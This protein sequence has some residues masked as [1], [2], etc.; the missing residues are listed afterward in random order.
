MGG[1]AASQV[2]IDTVS[3]L[4]DRSPSDI[5]EGGLALRWGW[6]VTGAGC[7][8]M[9]AAGGAADDETDVTARHSSSADRSASTRRSAALASCSYK[10]PLHQLITFS[11]EP[12][13]AV[14]MFKWI[15]YVSEQDTSLS[16]Q[17]EV[18]D[19]RF[20]PNAPTLL[21]CSFQ[22]RCRSLRRTSSCWRRRALS[23]STA[24]RAWCAWGP[25]LAAS[26]LASSRCS[27]SATAWLPAARSSACCRAV[28]ACCRA[29]FSRCTSSR[30]TDTCAH[31]FAHMPSNYVRADRSLGPTRLGLQVRESREQVSQVVCVN[32]D[33][34]LISW[35][36]TSYSDRCN[37]L[38]APEHRGNTC[39]LQH[40]DKL[41]VRAHHA[42]HRHLRALRQPLLGQ[43]PRLLPQHL[44]HTSHSTVTGHHK[45]L[46][47][48]GDMATQTFDARFSEHLA[49]HS[50]ARERQRRMQVHGN[51]ANIQTSGRSVEG[52]E[53]S[54][55]SSPRPVWP[56]WAVGRR[57]P[58]RI[59]AQQRQRLRPAPS[60]APP[61]ASPRP[62]PALPSA[63][64]PV[65]KGN[66]TLMLQLKCSS[67][68]YFR[69]AHHCYSDNTTRSHNCMY[70][71][72]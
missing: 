31:T 15:P 41:A 50:A 53:S 51:P 63:S 59:S 8:D 68:D 17:K 45:K 6:G 33:A 16:F 54:A 11:R 56:R 32:N 9:D 40:R 49:Q 65:R 61:P 2:N 44:M 71:W 14:H 52:P 7:S 55:P 19:P 62:P 36:I 26:T 37:I 38:E 22:I 18:L 66:S 64:L 72:C 58:G 60:L 3:S 67:K 10:K 42:G 24:A 57:R 12:P 70:A 46:R 27:A 47:R 21:V 43:F 25:S 69:T 35:C 1:R 23:A 29:T 28:S 13:T 20:P 30:S 5:L 34:D 48:R 4:A 39:G